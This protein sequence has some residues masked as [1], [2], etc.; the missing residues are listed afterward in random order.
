MYR[1]EYVI[2]AQACRVV[3]DDERGILLWHPVGAGFAHRPQPP[4]LDQRSPRRVDEL[5][6]LPVV[7][8]TWRDHDVLILVPPGAPYSV[9]WFFTDG[10]FAFWYVNLERPSQRW[11]RNGVQGNGVAGLDSFDHALDVLVEPDR[12]WRWKDEDELDERIGMPGYW[13]AAKAAEIRADGASVV[14]EVEAGRFPFDGTWCDFQPDPSWPV[15]PLPPAG[16]DTPPAEPTH[17]LS[18][19]AG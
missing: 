7:V 2:W 12:T 17:W 4:H 13:D 1:G 15:P 10:A 9:W 16:W 18:R 8:E 3:T 11:R 19:S 6:S 5:A 14:R